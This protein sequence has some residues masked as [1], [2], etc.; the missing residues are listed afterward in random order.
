MPVRMDRLRVAHERGATVEELEVIYRQ[1]FHRFVRVA[2]A[3]TR[4]RESA[5]DAVHDAFASALVHR[6]DYRGSGALEAWVWRSVVNAALR[7]HRLR[8]HEPLDDR[9]GPAE[10]PAVDGAVRG[11]VAALP[12]RQRLVLFL[13]YYADLDYRAIAEALQIEV[14]TVGST[15]SQAQAAVRRQLAEAR[16]S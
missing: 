13:R 14:G 4:S 1:L 15:L 12:E 2:E 8:A 3:I 7:T 10:E 5:L 6:G 9:A 11:V 16:G